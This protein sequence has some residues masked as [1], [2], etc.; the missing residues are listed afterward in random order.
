MKSKIENL[1]SKRIHELKTNL[2]ETAKNLS[3]AVSSF[4]IEGAPGDDY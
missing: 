1:V 3:G 2:N 4:E